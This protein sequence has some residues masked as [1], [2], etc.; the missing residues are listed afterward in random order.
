MSSSDMFNHS[1]VWLVHGPSL[2]PS[3]FFFC[4]ALKSR[5]KMLWLCNTFKLFLWHN[6][7]QGFPHKS[8]PSCFYILKNGCGFTSPSRNVIS[9][10]SY[11]RTKEEE[12]KN[13]L[14]KK[15]WY[16]SA[17]GCKCFRSGFWCPFS[18][19]FHDLLRLLTVWLFNRSI[20][21]ALNVFFFNQNV[22]F[23]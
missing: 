12:E 4:K 1:G 13:L 7:H 10:K 16:F 14:L 15:L 11:S 6:L 22:F 20:K 3:R 18:L 5:C 8:S 9:R 19:L 23:F 17:R 21:A 2:L